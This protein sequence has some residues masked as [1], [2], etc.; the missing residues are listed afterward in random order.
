M[1][2]SVVVYGVSAGPRGGRVAAGTSCSRKIV[3]MMFG[4][5]FLIFKLKRGS[6]ALL[7]GISHT[8]Q[9]LA[10]EGLSPPWNEVRIKV[11]RRLRLFLKLCVVWKPAY[12][13]HATMIFSITCSAGISTTRRVRFGLIPLPW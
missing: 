5:S 7:S 3:S 1:N 10:P 11:S 2:K 13:L 4:P 6:Q 9:D 12:C 8:L